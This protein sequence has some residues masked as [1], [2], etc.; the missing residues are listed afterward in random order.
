MELFDLELMCGNLKASLKTTNTVPTFPAIF[1]YDIVYNHSLRHVS[2]C[3]CI[4]KLYMPLKTIWKRVRENLIAEK[5]RWIGSYPC[6]SS[7]VFL[8]THQCWRTQAWFSP[9]KYQFAQS[10]EDLHRLHLGFHPHC[11]SQHRWPLTSRSP[12]LV[13]L[14]AEELEL[15]QISIFGQVT[16]N[17]EYQFYMEYL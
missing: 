13:L 15:I 8:L 6:Q 4:S 5:W 11:D 3:S 1:N 2:L 16:T 14:L 17:K 9:A 7:Q 10:N 12:C